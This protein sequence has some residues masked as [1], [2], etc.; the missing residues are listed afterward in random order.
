MSPDPV[1][2]PDLTNG[3]IDGGKRRNLREKMKAMGRREEKEA[4]TQPLLS[5]KDSLIPI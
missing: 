2:V 4:P 5:T 1:K 3:W